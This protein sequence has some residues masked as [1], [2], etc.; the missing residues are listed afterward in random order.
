MKRKKAAIVLERLSLLN[1]V[2]KTLAITWWD[3][4]REDYGWASN[5]GHVYSL[6]ISMLI[7]EAVLIC[8]LIY[9]KKLDK[10]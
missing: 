1:I 9:S 8:S 10:K 6:L 4:S 2:M 7:S 3:F 5:F